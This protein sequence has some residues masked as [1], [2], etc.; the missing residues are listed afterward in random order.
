M[1]SSDDEDDKQNNLKQFED[2]LQSYHFESAFLVIL[3]DAAKER[4]Q[5]HN[6]IPLGYDQTTKNRPKIN[7]LE[8][9][10]K[11]EIFVLLLTFLVA[12]RWDRELYVVRGPFLVVV[13]VLVV[14]TLALLK[15][16]IVDGLI[17]HFACVV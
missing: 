13:G 16:I 3:V 12:I 11:S 7:N 6:V 4:V 15:W 5:I 14:W 10:T 9:E 2:F 8:I 1:H 17:R